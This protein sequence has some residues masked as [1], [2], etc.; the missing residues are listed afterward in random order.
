MFDHKNYG[1]WKLRGPS[2]EILHYL[3][4]RAVRIKGK[5]RDNYRTYNY[6]GFFSQFLQPF[7]IDSAEFPCRDPAISSPYSFY[8]QNIYSVV[9]RS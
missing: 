3:C 8:S 6:H 4:K 9:E 1:D 7:Y 2:G 5:T